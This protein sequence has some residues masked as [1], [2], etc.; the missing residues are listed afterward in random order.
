MSPYVLSLEEK[1]F[2]K[3]LEKNSYNDLFESQCMTT[4]SVFSYIFDKI[5]GSAI[6][7]SVLYL[8]F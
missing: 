6:Y 5:T 7:T 1:E 2:R 8:M 3:L 4:S